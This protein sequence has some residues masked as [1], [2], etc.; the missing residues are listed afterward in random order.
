MIVR[1]DP[2][3]HCIC[4]PRDGVGRLQHL[5][6]VQRMMVGKV[7]LHAHG[8]RIEYLRRCSNVVL[9]RK[10]RQVREALVERRERLSEELDFSRVDHRLFLLRRAAAYRNIPAWT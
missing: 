10:G 1:I 3:G 7:I 9:R 6:G 5:S 8:D 4:K 2:E